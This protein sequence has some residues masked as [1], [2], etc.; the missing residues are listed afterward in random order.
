MNKNLNDGLDDETRRKIIDLS[1]SIIPNASIW[2]YGSRAKG[3]YTE[4]SDIDLVLEAAEPI[5]YFKIA[6]LKEV[7]SAAT[8]YYKFDIVDFNSISDAEF[9][10]DLQKSRILWKN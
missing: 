1:K 5:S 8:F 4:R 6:E 7:L 2:L 9:K 3:N 10:S